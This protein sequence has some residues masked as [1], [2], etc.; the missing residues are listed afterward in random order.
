MQAGEGPDDNKQ[1]FFSH[2]PLPATED[3]LHS[4]FSQFGEIEE[5]SLFRERRTGRSKGCGFVGA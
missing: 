5:L 3:D 4:L 2:V 1:L